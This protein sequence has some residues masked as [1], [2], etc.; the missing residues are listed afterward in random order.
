MG[1]G[2]FSPAEVIDEMAKMKHV[3]L[4][5]MGMKGKG[6]AILFLEALLLPLSANQHFPFL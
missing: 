4:I 3:D 6:R 1:T 2:R 5:V